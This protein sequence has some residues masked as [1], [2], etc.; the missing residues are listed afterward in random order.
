MIT[1]IMYYYYY[2]YYYY[3]D[4]YYYYAPGMRTR[5][6]VCVCVHVR[7]CVCFVCVC[8]CVCVYVYA[9]AHVCV[10]LSLSLSLSASPCEFAG[11]AATYE[12]C[13][14]RD[15]SVGIWHHRADAA[16]YGLRPP[17]PSSTFDPSSRVCPDYNYYIVLYHSSYYIII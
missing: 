1:I 12:V 10:C 16:R 13:L 14:N 3:Y 9:R 15:G 17:F 11:V 5:V 8:M 2:Y 4:D 7:T 6:C